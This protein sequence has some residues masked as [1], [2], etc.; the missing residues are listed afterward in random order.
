[1]SA[2]ELK[3]TYHDASI[4]AFN[5]GPR[6]ELRLEIALDPVWNTSRSV[7]LQFGAIGNLAEVTAFLR[8][9]PPKAVPEAYLA[10]IERLEYKSSRPGI[11]VLQLDGLGAIEIESSKVTESGAV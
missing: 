10:R 3:H 9:I 5:A 8:R 7:V 11:A 2:P 6:N 4:V 1:M